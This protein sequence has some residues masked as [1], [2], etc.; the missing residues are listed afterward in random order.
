MLDMNTELVTIK[1][2]LEMASVSRN[3]LYRDI[4]S[5]KIQ[6][7]YFG[8]NVRFKREDAERYAEEKKGSKWVKLWKEKKN[9]IT[10]QKN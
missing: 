2:V 9:D 5:K 1:D 6:A 8:R 10:Q 7:I 3:S 4:K